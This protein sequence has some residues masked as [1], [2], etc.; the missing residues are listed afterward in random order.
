MPGSGRSTSH[1]CAVGSWYLRAPPSGRNSASRPDR[2]TSCRRIHPAFLLNGGK[3]R[4]DDA[5]I[6]YYERC[7]SCTNRSRA[8]MRPGASGRR[9]S[10]RALPSGREAQPAEAAGGGL[11]PGTQAPGASPGLDAADGGQ[12]V[13]RA[14][15]AGG[16][17]R[18]DARPVRLPTF[19]VPGRD[20]AQGAR[21][22]LDRSC[23]WPY[24]DG[25]AT[26]DR[27]RPRA[28]RVERMKD[29]AP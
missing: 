22:A 3:A 7:A 18:S 14:T 17:A 6:A 2:P 21:P 12:I 19:V 5:R 10:G 15:I 1:Q 13:E 24:P 4:R 28:D 27:D 26:A 25:C 9:P 8:Q 11:D 23:D 16:R 20:T 29:E